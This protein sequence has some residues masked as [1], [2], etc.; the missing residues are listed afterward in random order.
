M[1]YMVGAYGFLKVWR[2]GKVQIDGGS[3]FPV[4][5]VPSVIKDLRCVHGE[6]IQVSDIL[7]LVR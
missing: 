4:P 5:I 1:F 6:H 7:A 3:L 2:V